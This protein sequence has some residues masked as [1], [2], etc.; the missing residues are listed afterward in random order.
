M[1]TI[2]KRNTEKLNILLKQERSLF[3]LKDLRL[4][5]GINNP[6]TLRRTVSRYVK[7]GA[8]IPIYRGF[9]SVLPIGKIDPLD[10]GASAFHAFCYV[11]TETVLVQAGIIFQI[12]Y[13][14]TYC[15]SKTKTI[16]IDESIYKSRQL[17]DKYLYNPAG[18]IDQPNY[19]IASTERA[20]ADMLYFSPRY[21]FDSHDLIDWKKVKA[22]QKEVGYI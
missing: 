18:I 22:I 13:G 14:Y 3:H 6:A 5:W 15:S 12:I 1:S 4:L 11:S 17:K 2:D 20:V 7:R 19:K 9:Y 16:Q 10:L 8:L 21:Y